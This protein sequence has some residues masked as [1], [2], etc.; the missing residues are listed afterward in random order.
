MTIAILSKDDFLID[1]ISF[2]GG[3]AIL[4]DK[5]LHTNDYV[6]GVIGYP[7]EGEIMINAYLEGR[8]Y[9]PSDAAL[10]GDTVI[11]W[12]KDGVAGVLITNNDEIPTAVP[13]L[14]NEC[15]V[16][17]SGFDAFLSTAHFRNYLRGGDTDLL[18]P[19]FC[20]AWYGVGSEESR[21]L[22]LFSAAA[23]AQSSF[24]FIEP[25]EFSKWLSK[26]FVPFTG[27]EDSH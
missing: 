26:T 16:Y 13:H 18:F 7:D 12:Y 23:R 20:D 19:Y 4:S 3:A 14:S 15:T 10:A 9:T 1:N 5:M 8:T 11:V 2:H 25:P 21:N 27:V 24:D 22:K 6:F 17:G